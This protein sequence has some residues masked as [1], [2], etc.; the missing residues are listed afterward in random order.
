[1]A[2]YQFPDG[3]VWGVATAAAQIEGAARVGRQGRV[4]LGPVRHAPRATSRTATRPRSPATT[5][6]ATRPTSTC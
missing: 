3:F 1:M 2:T 5:I 4:D 6:T